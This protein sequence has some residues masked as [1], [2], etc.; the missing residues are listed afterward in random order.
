MKI[1]LIAFG[2]A[3]F[4]LLLID[5]FV[6]PDFLEDKT[7]RVL[8]VVVASSV[9]APLLTS[10]VKSNSIHACPWNLQRYGGSAPYLRLF[11]TLPAQAA[12]GHCF[13]AGHAS[14]ALWLAAFAVFWLPDRPRLAAAAFAV[15]LMPGI[16]LGWVQQMRGAHFLTH[17]LWS[18]WLSSLVIAILARLLYAPAQ[19]AGDVSNTVK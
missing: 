13:P 3:L 19:V 7:R 17:T 16:A 1:V 4:V 2:L 15:G 10:V 11:E 9:L 14:G 5:C 18:I 12:A 6:L 8:R